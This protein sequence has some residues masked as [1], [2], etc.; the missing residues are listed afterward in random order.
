MMQELLDSLKRI[1]I[2]WGDTNTPLLSDANIGD[3]F[4][5]V[6]TTHRFRV[7]DQITIRDNINSQSQFSI[8]SIIDTQNIQV[9]PPV[10]NIWSITQN[11]VIHKTHYN[12]FVQGVY[13]GQPQNISHFPAITISGK[14]RNSQWL[15]LK[16]TKQSYQVEINIYVQSDNQQQTYR[17]LMRLTDMIQQGLKRNLY[18]LVGTSYTTALAANYISGD[19]AI[20]VNSLAPFKNFGEVRYPDIQRLTLDATLGND[21]IDVAASSIFT[22][23][24][25]ITVRDRNN[26]QTFT[27]LSL[28]TST[29][30]QLDANLNNNYLVD[31]RA[32][33]V[34]NQVGRPYYQQRVYMED[35]FKMSQFMISK[36]DVLNNVIYLQPS[37]DVSYLVQN[38]AKII[39]PT[40]FFFN[41]WP[42]SIQYGTI[43]KGT[44]LKA[45]KINF[46]AQE[47]QIRLLGPFDTSLS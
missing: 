12:N 9:S 31:D 43:F 17:D 13:L 39:M 35:A 22:V 26:S 10:Q 7:G 8:V 37:I 30:I 34:R 44:F 11:A 3:T 4:L 23:G 19:S 29:T 46:F 15:T 40:R 42:K 6:Y 38:G 47:E 28:P 20:L 16:S 2:R 25:S 18:P 36:L 41:S 27:V 1:C 14:S 32:Q 45:A 24:Q 21:T 33:I 5:N